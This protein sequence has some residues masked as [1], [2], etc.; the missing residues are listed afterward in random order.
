MPAR[1]LL[2]DDNQ[3]GILARKVIL[4]NAGY[5]VETALSGEEAWEIF[6][7]TQ[8]DVVV[9]DLRMGGMNG[10]ELI[11]LMRQS[12]SPARIILLS[13]FAGCLGLTEENSGADEVLVKSNT[14]AQELLRSVRKLAQPPRKGPASHRPNRRAESA[15]A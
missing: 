13:G 4:E 6:Q 1:V 8:F 5:A 3:F 9:T 10:V 12:G 14:E 2:V 11:A 7:K 15:G